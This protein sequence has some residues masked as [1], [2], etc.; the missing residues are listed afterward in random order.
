MAN[1]K[2]ER[3]FIALRAAVLDGVYAPGQRLPVSDLMEFLQ[4]SPTPIREALRLLQATGLVEHQ[5]H[6]GVIV[7]ARS[8]NQTSDT[9][10]MRLTLE[11][12]AARRAAA[13]GSAAQL[14]DVAD[15]FD[16]LRNL[17]ASSPAGRRAKERHGLACRDLLRGIR[18]AANSAVLAEFLNRLDVIAPHFP[19]ADSDAV[20]K[21]A[22]V[23]H[24]ITDREPVAA[25]EAMHDYIAWSKAASA[26]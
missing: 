8:S 20:R 13:V 1:T 24:A 9:L 19:V 26:L 15:Q 4:M 10:D 18:A 12:M 21:L 2:T 23:V 14:E 3:A 16:R 7:R 17:V 6:H 22:R 11:S 5:P 25:A